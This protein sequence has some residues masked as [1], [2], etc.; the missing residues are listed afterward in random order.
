M[1]ERLTRRRMPKVLIDHR[2]CGGGGCPKCRGTGTQKVAMQ[3]P[4]ITMPADE[5]AFEKQREDCPCYEG[6]MI[7]DGVVQCTH[8]SAQSEWCDSDVCPL[9]RSNAELTRGEAVALNAGL[10]PN[11]TKV[12]K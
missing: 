1:T 11:T 2:Y 8:V 6:V 7:N 4:Q 9:P 3:D 5:D 10:E 12:T